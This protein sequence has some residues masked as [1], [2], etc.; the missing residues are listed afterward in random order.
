MI[1]VNDLDAQTIIDQT[2]NPNLN[3]LIHNMRM[4]G[5]ALYVAG[6]NNDELD[7]AEETY[8]RLVLNHVLHHLQIS[9]DWLNIKLEQER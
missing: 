9:G 2:I 6:K 4:L 8:E 1:D 7:K 3:S 5:K